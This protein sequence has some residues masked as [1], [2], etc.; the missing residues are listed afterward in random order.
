MDRKSI[1]KYYI[2]NSIK[3]KIYLEFTSLYCYIIKINNSYVLPFKIETNWINKLLDQIYKSS[4][5]KQ[6]SRGR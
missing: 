1:Y 2:Y 4:Y 6:E 5:T 3:V